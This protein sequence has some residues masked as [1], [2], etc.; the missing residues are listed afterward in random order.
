MGAGIAQVAASH[1]C[2]VHLMDVDSDRT[3]AAIAGI[4]KRVDR[5]VEKGRISPQEGEGIKDRIEN[6]TDLGDFREVDFVIEAVLEDLEIKNEVFKTLLP[7][8]RP[9]AFLAT[10]TSSLSVSKIGEN[11]GE[12]SRVVGM[13][14]FNPVPLMPLV[15]IISG[16]TPTPRSRRRHSRSR[17]AGAKSSSAPPTH[18]G[19]S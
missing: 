15:E 4:A 7:H 2:T 14:F 18:R 10:N 5:M 17:R 1:N 12:A 6:T 9:S 13:H 11:L 16:R 19:S 3:D 8:L